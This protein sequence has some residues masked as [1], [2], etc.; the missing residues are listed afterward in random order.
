MDVTLTNGSNFFPIK[1]MHRGVL[2]FFFSNCCHALC[3]LLGL[4]SRV[5][6][7]T[8]H[9][10]PC[11]K[12]VHQGRLRN[13]NKNKLKEIQKSRRKNP[14]G[15]NALSFGKSY[16]MKYLF[17]YLLMYFISRFFIRNWSC[18]SKTY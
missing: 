15:E 2:E 16:R 11:K 14:Q 13:S 7:Y 4:V 17:E 8:L 5:N 3:K 18:K 12:Q 9:T 1:S 6:T 10:H